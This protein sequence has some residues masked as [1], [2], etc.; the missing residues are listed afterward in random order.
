L[1]PSDHQVMRT[2]HSFKISCLRSVS[3]KFFLPSRELHT[4]E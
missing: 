4:R 2:F 3:Q 1:S